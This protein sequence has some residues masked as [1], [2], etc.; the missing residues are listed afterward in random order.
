MTTQPPGPADF[1][2][3]VKPASV[4]ADVDRVN[5]GLQLQIG[6]E[7]DLSLVTES[8]LAAHETLQRRL[9][10]LSN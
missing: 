4:I 8:L 7:S 3:P 5:V 1:A 2:R 10:D 9:A 6:V